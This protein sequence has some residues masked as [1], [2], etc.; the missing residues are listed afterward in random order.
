MAKNKSNP[1]VIKNYFY[2]T[3]TQILSI[4]VP[5]ITTPYVSRVLRPEGIGIYSY[6]NAI[7]TFFTLFAALGMS[8]YGQ[9]E[10]AFN[11]DDIEKRSEAFFELF[12]FK[13]ITAIT[14]IVIYSFFINTEPIQY[15]LYYQIQCLSLFSVL[16]D[17]SWYFQ[18]LE[19]FKLMAYK[20]LFVRLF[21]I[22]LIFMFVKSESDLWLYILICVGAG[23]IANLLLYIP[24]KE[25]ISKVDLKS[26]NPFKHV[27]GIV[28]FF[29]PVLA[30]QLYTHVDKIMLGK[31]TYSSN[32]NGYYEQARRITEVIIMFVTSINTVLFPRI[33]FL[34][35]QKKGGAISEVLRKSYRIM[36]T[37]LLPVIVGL[38][39]IADSFVEWF[40][41]PGYEKVGILLRLA[42]PLLVF[43][44][45]G[46]FIGVEYLN[47]TKQ[48]NKA[49]VVYS[50]S[51]LVNIIFNFLLIPRLLSIGAMY[52]SILA[53]FVSC[54]L[55]VVLLKK[56]EYQFG[57][58]SG[59]WK[60][61]LASIIM[62][63]IVGIVELF[64]PLRGFL[65]TFIEIL[66]GMSTYLLVLVIM[67]DDNILFELISK[68]L[69]DNKVV[70]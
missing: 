9:R 15:K 38:A 44:C 17:I 41:G 67:K 53:E 26:I 8:A 47:P 57:L 18:G 62:G 50:I 24:L 25:S 14:V 52:A 49:T 66:T 10:I 69:N 13:C 63:I 12:F 4:I 45:I 11:R 5:L 22:A 40:F 2:H 1:S 35:A 27:K 39:V 55:Q 36:I 61:V 21:S 30:V 56:S 33:A 48:Q 58:L 54:S 51:A 29:L 23:L 28:E 20:T 7:T 6:T 43:M 60:Y 19:E 3:F 37:I 59:K 68:K 42:C 65:L 16:V 32:E 46:N 31:M 70:H 34:Y 64:L